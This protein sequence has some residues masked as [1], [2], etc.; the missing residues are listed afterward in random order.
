MV[1]AASGLTS[2][3]GGVEW[4]PID[5][6]ALR[7]GYRSDTVQQL[8]PI[9]GMSAGIGLS[10]WGAEFSYAWLPLGD[11]GTGQYFSLTARFGKETEKRRNLIYYQ[12]IHDRARS[13]G[14]EPDDED[15][16]EIIQLIAAPE[17]VPVASAPSTTEGT[18]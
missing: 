3:R 10:F 5:P 2:G 17:R 9:A 14:E 8:S 13:A 15:L 1:Q 18:R 6:L 7:A 11:L 16:Q 4:R 12:P